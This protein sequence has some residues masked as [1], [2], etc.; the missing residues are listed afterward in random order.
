MTHPLSQVLAAAGLSAPP[1]ADPAIT[2]VTADSRRVTPGMLFVAIPGTRADGS[3]FIPAA[4]AAG[5][6]AIVA[7]RGT[8]APGVPVIGVDEPRRAL[9]LLAAFLAGAQPDHVV[10]VTGTNGKTSTVDFLRQ[11]WGHQ[12]RRAASIGTLG[13]IADIDLPDCGPV[14]TTPDSVGLATLLAAMARGGVT[15]VAIEASSHG[16]DQHRL[17]GLRLSAAGFT[18]LTR[19]HLDYHGTLDAYRAA[20]LRLFDTL[21]PPDGLMAAN[22]DMDTATLD[23]LR[24]IAARRGLDLRLV[25]EA[26]DAIRLLGSTPLPEGQHLRI[27]SGGVARDI[28]LAL[29]GRFQ[30]DNALLAAAL[31]APGADGLARAI[32][33]LPALRGVRGR[34]ERAALLPNGAAAYVDYAHTPDAL[35]RLLDALRPHASGRLIAVFGAG[36]DRDR[37]KRPLMG[38]EATRRADIAIVTDDNPRT[39]DPAF[40]RGEVLAGAPGA[41]EIGDRARAIAEGLSMLRAGDVLVVAGK[42]H[43][44]GQTIGTATLPFD[45]ASVIRDLAGVRA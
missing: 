5:A 1:G 14:L 26:G 44:Q 25:G 23:A 35:A 20:K 12:H 9:A 41:I 3:A 16:L 42:G 8:P 10:A 19:D 33:L 37:G 24:D 43:E 2:G 18:N 38:Q 39:E 31:A 6:A 40:I 17:D 45:D 32:D 15:D 29:P 7:P 27:A 11:I 34:M 36:G 13:V 30:A 28:V 22:A 21:L 4:I